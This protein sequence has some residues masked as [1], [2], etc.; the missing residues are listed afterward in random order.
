MEVNEQQYQV[1]KIELEKFRTTVAAM[2]PMGAIQ[3]AE[4]LGMESM[5]EEL[6]EYVR[7]YEQKQEMLQ[8]HFDAYERDLEIR[9]LRPEIVELGRAIRELGDCDTSE[10]EAVLAT[11]SK[12]YEELVAKCDYKQDFDGL[13]NTVMISLSK[14]KSGKII[15]SCWKKGDKSF[16]PVKGAYQA[17]DS[18]RLAKLHLT[19]LHPEMFWADRLPSDN[20]EIMGHFVAKRVTTETGAIINGKFIMDRE[21]EREQGN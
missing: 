2:V 5:I 12:R 9:S 20:P 6:D 19:S 18:L 8:E 14:H 10:I 21:R 4:K 13:V 7:I 3:E 15:S 1:T 11:K 16:L 17:F